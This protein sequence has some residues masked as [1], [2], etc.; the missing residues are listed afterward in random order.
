M[1]NLAS[2]NFRE[3]IKYLEA[4]NLKLKEENEKLKEEVRRLH[5]ELDIPSELLNLPYQEYEILQRNL[6][7]LNNV[8]GSVP[9]NVAFSLTFSI[10]YT[11]K[12]IGE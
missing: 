8:K 6:A 7:E 4:E 1:S 2:K 3:E 10:F 11:I 12:G 9:Q 5:K